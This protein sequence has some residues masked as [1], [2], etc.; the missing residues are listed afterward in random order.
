MLLH[1]FEEYRMAMSKRMKEIEGL[2]S[3]FW[4]SMVDGKASVATGMLTE[5][6]VMVSGHGLLKFD[7][8]SYEKMASKD[9]TK[10]VDFEFSD[11]DVVFPNDD[12]AVA[13]YRVRQDMQAQGKP[14]SSQEAFD[15]STWVRMNGDWKC[16]AHTESLQAPRH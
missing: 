15:S 3:A 5:P 8:A 10:L 11:F 6:A 7:H 1:S 2:E 9:E 13:S 12:V 4:Q 16:V 14:L